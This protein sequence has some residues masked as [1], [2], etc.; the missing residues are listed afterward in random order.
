MRHPV[1]T[2]GCSTEQLGDAVIG[3]LTGLASGPCAALQNGPSVA[4]RREDRPV[5]HTRGSAL[6]GLDAPV[7]NVQRIVP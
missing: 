2:F 3:N 6:C 7:F 1:S 4:Q 5:S